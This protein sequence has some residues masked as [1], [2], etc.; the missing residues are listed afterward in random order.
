VSKGELLGSEAEATFTGYGPAYELLI[1]GTLGSG[2]V[3][4]GGLLG[5]D[6][7]EPDVELEIA[8]GGSSSASGVA[9]DESLGVLV[10]GPFVDWF[11]DETG[12]GHAGAMI[13]LGAIG[14]EGDD[15]SASSGIGGSLFGGYDFWISDQWSLGVEGRVLVVSAKRDV[16]GEEFEDSATGF[17]VLFTA[18]LH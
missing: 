3:L 15:D 9:N 2:F 11:F 12:G 14:L 6:L 5:Q 17:Q 18:L 8:G 7:V 10:I 16:I 4:G 1:G 13:G